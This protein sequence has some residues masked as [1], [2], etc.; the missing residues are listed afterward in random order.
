MLLV[1]SYRIRITDTELSR[2]L[3]ASGAVLVRGPK[4]CGKTESARRMSGSVL[5]VDRD[6]NVPLLMETDPAR[7]LQGETPRLIDEWQEQPKLWDFIRHEVDARGKRSQ[8]ILTGSANPADD[9]RLH[10]G[11]GRFTTLDM[12]TMSW[13]ELGFSTGIVSLGRLLTGD[14]LEFSDETV[15]LAF[16]AERLVTGGFP[17]LF[18]ASETQ[19]LDVNRAYMEL[20]AEVDISRVSGM[21]RDPQKVSA[22]LRSLARNTATLVE[23]TTLAADIGETERVDVSRPTVTDYLTVLDRLMITE[24]QPAW[25]THVRS[26]ASLRKASKRH[27]V[28]PCLAAAALGVDSV[29]LLGDMKFT[30][31][32]FESLAIHDLRVYAQANDAR[33]FHYRDSSGLEVDAIVQKRN[34]DWCAF[35]IKLGT[36]QFEAAASN[37]QKFVSMLDMEKNKPPKSLNIITG[38]GISHQ[39][40]DGVNVLSIASLGV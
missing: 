23:V 17:G 6:A 30:G 34:G 12:R 7:L 4:A 29:A 19:A 11:A 18:D 16:I 13:Q 22:L 8:F 14:D 38:T 27:F 32:L 21:K 28:D 15:A 3:S 24:N 9:V 10:S 20:L 1:M 37:L 31:F 39:R 35:E 25:N 33:V 36:G 40:A 26:S 5:S 2:K